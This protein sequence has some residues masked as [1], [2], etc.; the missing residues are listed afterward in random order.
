MFLIFLV[1]IRGVIYSMYI[2]EF[3]DNEHY[4]VQQR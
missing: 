2:D 3:S 4:V 1:N